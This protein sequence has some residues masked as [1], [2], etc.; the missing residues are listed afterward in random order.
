MSRAAGS[1]PQ[2][3]ATRTAA[4]RVLLRFSTSLV[5][6]K[7]A[8][9]VAALIATLL[10]TLLA[11]APL[12]TRAQGIELTLA[13]L[14]PAAEGDGVELNA[15]FDFELPLVLEDAVNRGVALHFVLEFE[16]IHERWYWFDRRRAQASRNWRLSFSPLT[17]EYRLAR[18]TLAL[19]FESLSDALATMRRVSGWKVIDAGVLKSGESYNA[20]V[21]L[22]LDEAQLPR[23]FQMSA[24]AGR[25]WTLPSAWHELPVHPALAR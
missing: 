11:A 7:V 22:R 17:R 19:P 18:G 20:R 9:K 16:L 3:A 8:A 23:A 14:Q 1:V 5:A 6:A 13:A 15:Q 4:R 12:P 2:C 21:R 24:L 25:D 10:A